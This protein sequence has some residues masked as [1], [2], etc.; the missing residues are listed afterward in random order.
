MAASELKPENL[1]PAAKRNYTDGGSMYMIPTEI[2]IE[3][4][5]FKASDYSK[6]TLSPDDFLSYIGKNGT[7]YTDYFLSKE[8]I[9]DAIMQVGITEYVDFDAGTCSFDSAAFKKLIDKIDKLTSENYYFPDVDYVNIGKNARILNADRI[10]SFDFF[11]KKRAVYGEDV[12]TVGLPSE[13]SGAYIMT[14]LCLAVRSDSECP[15]GAFKFVEYYF[16][17]FNASDREG[18]IL[19]NRKFYDEA[20]GELRKSLEV[21][22]FFGT[23][24]K[25]TE[26]DI[27][28]IEAAVENSA[29]KDARIEAV[30]DYVNDY[31]DMYFKG[32]SSLDV[33]IENLQATVTQYLNR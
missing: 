6:K 32:E 33:A 21:T 23:K 20:V 28:A 15:E 17:H 1:I 26:A 11:G 13:G 9:M 31:T 14:S 18:T 25:V 30:I 3:T 22:D 27:D 19:A 24:T 29:V 2:G 4:Y 8:S 12:K 10:G 7:L 5:A 16:N